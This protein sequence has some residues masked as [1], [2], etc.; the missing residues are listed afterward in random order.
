[1][2]LIL[3]SSIV[4]AA[5]RRKPGQTKTDKNRVTKKPGD[6]RDVPQVGDVG[7]LFLGY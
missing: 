5:E 6:R 2:G 3:D 1:M 7:S 4:I